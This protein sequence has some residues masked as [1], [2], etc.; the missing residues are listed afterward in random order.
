MNHECCSA[1]VEMLMNSLLTKLIDQCGLVRTLCIRGLGNMSSLG[2]EHVQKHS[3]TI[4]SAMMAGLDDKDD[5]ND[6]ITFESMNG[7]TKIIAL[8]DENNVRPILINILLRIRPC[9]E[10]DKP[11]IRASSY[12]LFGELAR[13]G[14]GPSKEPYLEQIHSNFV[15]FIL[16]LNEQDDQVK[17]ACKNVLRQVGPLMES[18]AINELFQA[19]LVDAKLLHYGEFINDLSKLLVII[20]YIDLFY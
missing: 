9:F 6:D 18:N 17:K 8:I 13:F 4:L 1:F 10:K 12:N 2:K 14:L 19:S 7:L 15:S 16:H 3:T 20:E 5:L 11:T